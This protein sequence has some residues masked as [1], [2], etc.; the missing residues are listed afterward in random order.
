MLGHIDG[1]S[2]CPPLMINDHAGKGQ[3]SQNAHLWEQV[4]SLVISWIQAP[5]DILCS[6]LK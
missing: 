1:S 2:E 5:S 6:L 4:N 3:P